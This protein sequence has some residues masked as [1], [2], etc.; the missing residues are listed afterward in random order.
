MSIKKTHFLSN[1]THKL[2]SKETLASQ[3]QRQEKQTLLQ[4]VFLFLAC[5]MFSV[6]IGMVV[7]ERPANL[8][9]P[10]RKVETRRNGHTGELNRYPAR[11]NL[12]IVYQ[13]IG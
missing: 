3:I 13:I 6:V 2:K 12:R 5:F 1:R 10:D 4:T 9:S 11:R 8:A 7:L